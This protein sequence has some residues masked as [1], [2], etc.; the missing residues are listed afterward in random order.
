MILRNVPKYLFVEDTFVFGGTLEYAFNIL[1]MK[2][3]V[4]CVMNLHH[5][6]MQKKFKQTSSDLQVVIK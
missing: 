5:S 6:Q 2:N 4:K 1:D 3:R